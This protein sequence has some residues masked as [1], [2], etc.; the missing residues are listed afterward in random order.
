MR[1]ARHCEHARTGDA[2]LSNDDLVATLVLWLDVALA[3]AHE[4]RARF[5][6]DEDGEAAPVA[7]ERRL[8]DEYISIQLMATLTG[9]ARCLQEATLAEDESA[10][11]LA[12]RLT[13]VEDRIANAIEHEVRYQ[14]ERG[15]AWANPGASRRVLEQYTERASALKKHF[16]R[17]LF[18]EP[19]TFQ[20]SDR[21]H[22]WV[23]AFVALVASTWACAW[24]MRWRVIPAQRRFRSARVW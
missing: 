24:Q 20:V 3:R 14:R 5:A 19:E 22:N 17:V 12:E 15:F 8:V 6:C 7:R 18:L 4:A 11:E 13:P 2:R 10:S 9:A 23:S 21:I 16:Q 1:F